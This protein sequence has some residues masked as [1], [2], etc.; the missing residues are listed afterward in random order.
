MFRETNGLWIEGEFDASLRESRTIQTKL[1]SYNKNDDP[2]HLA[3]AFAKLILQGKIN[4]ALRLLE[5]TRSGGVLPLSP[6]TLNELRKK[7]PTAN[8]ADDTVLMVGA[9]PFV[10]PAMFNNIDE[11]VIAKAAL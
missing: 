11:D 8:P 5:K 2:E 4:P 3:K 9:V 1:C 7:H 6:Q 10:D